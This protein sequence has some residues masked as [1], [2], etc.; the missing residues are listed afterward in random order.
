MASFIKNAGK[1]VS[2]VRSFLRESASGNSLKYS[3]EKNAKHQLF[4]PYTVSQVTAEDGSQVEVKKVYAYSA[5][6]HEW[7][8]SDN[9][10]HCA[11][12]LEGIFDTDDEGNQINDG[13]CPFCNRINDA[14]DIH[15]YRMELAESEC[16]LDPGK[17]RDEYMKSVV[18]ELHKEKKAST[19]KPY[20]YLLVAQ[21][22][23]TDGVNPVIGQDGLPEF[24]LKIMKNSSSRSD[25][26]NETF[27]NSGI[28]ME[29]GILAI[30]YPNLDDRM[31]IASQCTFA[32]LAA[33]NQR[34]ITSKY[35]Q[36]INKIQEEAAKFDW[37]GISKS[38]P[39]W[40]GMST[41]QAKKE[42]DSLFRQWDEFKLAS[43]KDPNVRYL[44]YVVTTP[45]T[46]P[47]LGSE[48]PAIGAP[49]VNALPNIGNMPAPSIGQ[50]SIPQ[51]NVAPQVNPQ[52]A[53]Q[54]AP[55]ATPQVSVAPQVNPQVNVAPQAT[56]QVNVAPSFDP[57]EA[58]QNT[59]S[60]L[61]LG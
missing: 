56:P 20:M 57:N 45:S 38:F 6:V 31:V 34:A 9:K 1:K 55:Q 24:E 48:A 54:V 59:G 50:G 40:K 23:T 60:T 32:A 22:K 14:W 21:L 3:G 44:E 47:S 18:R 33:N 58:F 12:C 27:T 53:P 49:S 51:V 13:T 36:L 46:R 61:N 2:D 4:I 37:E 10:F 42:T 41:E 16:T 7:K 43:E 39:E 17:D 15:N 29:G 30:S 28:D 26:I 52:V 25:K 11:V 19:P 35:P 5:N 8:T